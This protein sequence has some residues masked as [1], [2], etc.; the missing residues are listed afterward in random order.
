MAGGTQ[1]SANAGRVAQLLHIEI[2]LV[3]VSPTIS[4]LSLPFVDWGRRFIVSAACM[5]AGDNLQDASAFIINTGQVSAGCSVTQYLM[6]YGAISGNNP[7]PLYFTF[8]DLTDFLATSDA[9]YDFDTSGAF[10]PVKI[11]LYCYTYL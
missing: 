8:F 6:Q 11:Y 2:P 4:R 9:V 3:V 1:P 5:D 10:V 7:L